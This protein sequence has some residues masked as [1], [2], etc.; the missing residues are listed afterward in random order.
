MGSWNKTCGLSNLHIKSG[1]KAYVFL[2]EP[3]NESDHCYATHLFKPL[4]LPFETTYNDYGG[5]EDSTGPG[6]PIIMEAIKEHLHEIELGDNKYHDIAVKKD[7]FDEA[8]FFEAVHE[9]RLFIENRFAKDEDDHTK[10]SYVMFRKDVVDHILE[11]RVI[12]KYVGDGKGTGGWDNNY[13]YYKF[14][15]IVA[16]ILP[17]IQEVCDK[18]IDARKEGL[19]NMLFKLLG[20]LEYLFDWKHPNKAAQWLRGDGYRYCR[21]VDMKFA[22]FEMF[23]DDTVPTTDQVLK[24]EAVLTEYL[25]GVFIDSF[26]EVTRK[27]WIPAGHEGSQAQELDEYRLLIGAMNKVIDAEQAEYDYEN[28]VDEEE[29]VE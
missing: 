17:M 21:I 14:E 23:K 4:L 24:L 28:G 12:E 18:I 25:K 15:D 6:F 10:L 2:L 22:F 27:S 3:G 11:N 20:G 16:D 13:I 9:D 1:E 29:T 5:G 26:M 7:K 19:D 8:L